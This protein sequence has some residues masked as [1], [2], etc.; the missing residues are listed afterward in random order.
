MSAQQI[1]PGSTPVSG[2]VTVVQPTG[3]NLH[4][5]LDSGTTTVTQATGTNLH[6]VVDSGTLTAVT[7]LT[8]AL[9]AGNNNIGDVDVASVPTLT[10]KE[11]YPAGSVTI[12]ISPQSIASSS[13]FVAGVE[14]DSI[15]NVSNLD[16]DHQ[17]SGTWTAG[18][19][20][21]ANTQVQIW[22]V[23]CI[24]D[25]LGATVTWPDVFDG[26]ASAETATSA[27]ILQSCGRLG[28]VLNVDTTTTDRIYYAAPF[29]VAALFGGY[30]PSRYVI[31]ITQNTGATSNAT[32]GN[33]VW[34]YLRIRGTVS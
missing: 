10:V 30:L 9:P 11:N 23:A 12:G 1:P 22:V 34:K 4:A 33:F 32:A 16:L 18:T 19:S 13:T 21:A 29:S 2:T 3:T 24:S 7:T 20:P 15:S 31:F 14:S 6:T 27:G 5:V 8:N 25:D 26:T 28:A 17:V